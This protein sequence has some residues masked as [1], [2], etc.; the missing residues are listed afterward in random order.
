M[1]RFVKYYLEQKG[2][3]SEEQTMYEFGSKVS[4]MPN[5]G[6]ED[7][8][9]KLEKFHSVNWRKNLRISTSVPDVWD[10][11]NPER[12]KEKGNLIHLLLSEITTINQVENVVN[13]SFEKGLFD[14]SQKDDLINYLQKIISHPEVSPYFKDNLD[15]KMEAE[16]LLDTG[17]TIRPDRLI[18]KNDEVIIIDYKTGKPDPSHEAQIIKYAKVL[19]DMG[20]MN[21]K[22]VLIY[23][24][25][26]IAVKTLD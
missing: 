2:V 20:Y 19:S 14:Q 18:I 12:N 8:S 13:L 5:T 1:P 24:S 3:W 22:K 15:V 10:V 17:K 11:D 7:E 16:I 26:S 4:A 23:L 6:F 25:T 9:I 21:I